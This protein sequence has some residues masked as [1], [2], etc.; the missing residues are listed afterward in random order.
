MWPRLMDPPIVNLESCVTFLDFISCHKYSPE[1]FTSSHKLRFWSGSPQTPILHFIFL[2]FELKK[3]IWCG[4]INFMDHF[5]YTI[6]IVIELLFKSLV[7]WSNQA[8]RKLLLSNH[9]SG[10][11]SIINHFFDKEFNCLCYISLFQSMIRAPCRLWWACSIF[12]MIFNMHDDRHAKLSFYEFK[13][14]LF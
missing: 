14:I 4:L 13:F 2:F 5:T 10:W 9:V 1:H 12:W 3:G 7:K 8:I 11:L 6:G